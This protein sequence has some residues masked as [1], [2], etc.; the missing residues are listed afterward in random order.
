MKRIIIFSLL[1]V[2]VC[3]C[4]AQFRKLSEVRNYVGDS[5]KKRPDKIT[6]NTLNK[7]FQGVV[8][9]TPDIVDDTVTVISPVHGWIRF[10]RKDSTAYIFDTIGVRR[11]RKYVPASVGGGGGSGD[12]VFTKPF[13]N[14]TSLMGDNFYVRP[15]NLIAQLQG[16]NSAGDGGGT[17][18]Y[19]DGTSNANHDGIL[20]IKPTSVSGAGRWLKIFDGVV[21]AK[22]AGV[23]TD[24][25][26]Q[27]SLLGTLSANSTVKQ[28]LFDNGSVTIS[29]TVNFHG[30]TISFQ[31][32]AQIIGSRRSR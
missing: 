20:V 4:Q 13:S 11:W 7:A 6:A 22:E 17:N 27:A 24:G 25:T 29:S 30:K 12:S 2:I 32:D 15:G 8:S 26:N 5:I 9:F 23:K 14:V 16:Y 31:N 19:W 18:F 21:R 28:I 1:F 10:Q 3:D